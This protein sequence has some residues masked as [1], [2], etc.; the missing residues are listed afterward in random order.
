MQVSGLQ[1]VVTDPLA[2]GQQCFALV[3]RGLQGL[4]AQLQFKVAVVL[5]VVD[6]GV[7]VSV[8]S[9]NYCWLPT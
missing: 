8:V 6:D 7:V 3:H 4:C 2:P 9:C 1:E 5:V